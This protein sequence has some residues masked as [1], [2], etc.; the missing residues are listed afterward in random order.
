MKQ[1][2]NDGLDITTSEPLMIEPPE[3]KAA[4]LQR[5][6]IFSENISEQAKAQD[7]KNQ[8]T[9]KKS[10]KF[11]K[12]YIAILS[13]IVLM[14]GAG[15]TYAWEIGLF[16]DPVNLKYDGVSDFT[17]ASKAF[18][19]SKESAGEIIVIPGIDLRIPTSSIQQ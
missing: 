4:G 8:R 16:E 12:S 13:G 19:V 18:T 9:A 6:A 11:K 3:P 15:A 1:T 7:N 5:E 14:S 10:M 17:A 2:N